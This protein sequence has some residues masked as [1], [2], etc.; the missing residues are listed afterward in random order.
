MSARGAY[1]VGTENIIKPQLL[2]TYNELLHRVTGAMRDHLLESRHCMPLE[3]VLDGMPA[4]GTSRVQ[5]C[6][7][8][9]RLK[10]MCKGDCLVRRSERLVAHE[11]TVL[12]GPEPITC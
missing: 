10:R 2:R 12:I 4:L 11:R 6:E 5:S 1:E 9:C 8:S 3:A 7:P